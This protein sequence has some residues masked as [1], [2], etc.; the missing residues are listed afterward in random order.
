MPSKK[1]SKKVSKTP[2]K[3][4]PEKKEYTKMT[5]QQKNKV[6]SLLKDYI[7]KHPGISQDEI[8]QKYAIFISETTKK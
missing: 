2:K 7:K 4:E 8:K 5:A 6:E 3:E 1:K